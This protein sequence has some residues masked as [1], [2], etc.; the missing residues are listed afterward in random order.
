MCTLYTLLLPVLERRSP[1]FFFFFRFLLFIFVET[2]KRPYQISPL[3][4]PSSSSKTIPSKGYRRCQCKNK[5]AVN[6]VGLYH[7][8]FGRDNS[9]TFEKNMS[10]WTLHQQGKSFFS[11]IRYLMEHHPI[12]TNSIL[13]LHLWLAGDLSAQYI[14]YCKE[15]RTEEGRCVKRKG[16]SVPCNTST[17]SS[18]SSNS[19]EALAITPKSSI[20]AFTI[21]SDRLIKSASYGAFVTGPLLAVWYPFLDRACQRYRISARY[22]VWGAPIFK[23]LA[24]EVVLDPPFLSMFFAYMNICEGGTIDTFR[25]KIRSEFVTSW[26]TSLVLWP[27]I[28]LLTF[29]YLPVYATAPIVNAVS[30]A[31]DGFLSHRNALSREASIRMEEDRTAEAN[32]TEGRPPHLITMIQ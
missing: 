23:V 32:S 4:I 22:G 10:A 26:L 12:A 8:V 16:T 17:S 21:D 27:P 30:V 31:W 6:S 1:T 24:D 2:E 3:K 29:R 5:Q 14:E 7:R 15:R 28:M 20:Q 13:S 9:Q 18:G 19:A 25:E 11:Q